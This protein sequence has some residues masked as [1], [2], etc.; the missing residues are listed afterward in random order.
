MKSTARKICA[1]ALS[2]V[3]A[4]SVCCMPF[5][6][7]SLPCSMTV[8]AETEAEELIHA[9]TGLHYTVTDGIVTITGCESTVT[10]VNIPAEI[11]GLPVKIIGNQA[12]SF[13]NN[14]KTAIIAEGVTTIESSAFTNCRFITSIDLPSTVTYIGDSA[15]QTCTRLVDIEIPD[16]VTVI[17][18]YAFS[19]CALEQIVIPE[20]VTEIK[21]YAFDGNSELLEVSIPSTV[22]TIGK[23]AFDHCQLL[24]YVIIPYGVVSIGEAAFNGCNSLS[25]VSLPESLLYIGKEAFDYCR[26]LEEIT[27]PESLVYLDDYAFNDTSI[28]NFV[29]PDSVEYVGTF[30]CPVDAVTETVDGVEYIGNWAVGCDKTLSSFTLREGTVGI[31]EYSF[32]AFYSTEITLTLPSTFK[33]I[34]Q[35]AF[36][37][38]LLTDIF[39]SEDNPYLC[40]VD[41]VVF[42]K[43]MTTLVCYPPGRTDE[44]YTVPENVYEIGDSAFYYCENLTSVTV[45]DTLSYIGDYAFYYCKALNNVILPEGVQRIG[46]FAFYECDT[47]TTAFDIP[48]SVTSVGESA[49]SGSS[50][51]VTRY[52]N[53][54]VDDWII[55][56]STSSYYTEVEI[57]PCVRGIA[58]KAFD[59]LSFTSLTIPSETQYIGISSFEDCDELV[60]LTMGEGVLSIDD[61]A[62][63][64]CTKLETPEIPDSVF[65]IGAIAFKDCINTIEEIDGVS[66]VDSWAVDS[67]YT[68]TALSLRNGTR[69]IAEMA[70][71]GC[72]ELSSSVLPEGVCFINESAFEF[73]LSLT[74]ATLPESLLAI[75]MYAFA[76]CKALEEVTIP[77]NTV[78]M[79]FAAFAEC[80]ALSKITVL[81][82]DCIIYPAAETISEN[83]VIYGYTDS[84]AEEYAVMFDRQFVALN[85]IPK[86]KGDVNADGEFNVADAVMLQKYLLSSGTLTDW[87]MGDLCEDGIIDIFDF[88]MMRKM[89]IE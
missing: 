32:H 28:T 68:I 6:G 42:S 82:P 43:D 53:A 74:E 16:G 23:F 76:Y 58:D 79:D 40:D 44:S 84:T 14:I 25:Y 71:Y 11:D 45:P 56:G 78:Y 67:D 52:N 46:D 34:C 24:Q 48:D 59:K 77:E 12:F 3:T 20:G 70:F 37:D 61:Y 81:N 89:L 38:S 60:T 83:A 9:E 88:I 30:A 10:N 2:A 69:G 18:D 47:F 66:Y 85:N 55:Y 31:S 36:H 33:Y 39:V 41:G 35:P 15:F 75:D 19:S 29:I 27:L 1:A 65:H 57:N 50:A 7:G 72:T 13:N 64:D 86:V 62:F 8:F 22:T 49:F 87:T 73:C 51:I 4:F 54:M 5:S 80:E 63:A 17:N 21:P 26:E